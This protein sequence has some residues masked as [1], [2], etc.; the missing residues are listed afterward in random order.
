VLLRKSS[1]RFEEEADKKAGRM[2]TCENDPLES[3]TP[4][5]GFDMRNGPK[6]QVPIIFL[7]ICVQKEMV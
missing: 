7:I 4:F 3:S 5:D 2:L 6:W 1:F